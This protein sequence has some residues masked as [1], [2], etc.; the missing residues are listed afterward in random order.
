MTNLTGINK[1]WAEHYKQEAINTYGS[2]TVSTTNGISVYV[3]IDGY[4]VRFS[5]HET[6]ISRKE[7]EIQ[8]SLGMINGKDFVLEQIERAKSE[9]YKKIKETKEIIN[10]EYGFNKL[11]PNAKILKKEFIRFSK[12]GQELFKFTYEIEKKVY[13]K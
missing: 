7:S 4:T 3:K 12:K 10:T 6:G 1:D 11:Q 2:A 13:T 5:D 9:N 8:L